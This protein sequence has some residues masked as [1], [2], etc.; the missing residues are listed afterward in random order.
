[1]RDITA[2]CALSCSCSQTLEKGLARIR[3]QTPA[4]GFF[5]E[6]AII[7]EFI[8]RTRVNALVIKL[9]D[10]IDDCSVG[11]GL[12]CRLPVSESLHA[13]YSTDC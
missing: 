10:N 11:W 2:T 7:K 4:H 3:F 8:S 9:L 1:M 6:G 13:T 12:Q 5:D